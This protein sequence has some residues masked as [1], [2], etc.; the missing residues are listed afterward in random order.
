[1]QQVLPIVIYT[2]SRRW[3]APLSVKA[4]TATGIAALD[5][6][7]PECRP[8]LLDAGNLQ[9]ED[10]RRNRAAALLAL[11]RCEE[12]HRIAELAATLFELLRRRGTRSLRRPLA[13]ATMRMLAN[14][15]GGEASKR[16]DDAVHSALR[17]MEE[18]TMLAERITQWCQE[19]LHQ[20]RVE[21]RTEGLRSLLRR[22]AARRFGVAA[23]NTLSGLVG[24]VVDAERLAEVGELIVVSAS[25]DELLEQSRKLLEGSDQALRR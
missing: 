17:Y 1:M 9:A 4:L 23:G 5:E 15:F 25:A 8:V 2:G 6:Y 10:L 7:Q 20:G 24:S 18:P 13:E 12:D 21:G 16:H 11:Q 22:Q 19:W 14:R 3:N